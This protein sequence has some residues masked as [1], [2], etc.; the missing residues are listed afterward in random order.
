MGRPATIS[1][2]QILQ[3]ARAVFTQKGFSSAT[4]ADIARELRVT[5]AA[6]LRH[7]DSK[8]TLFDAAMRSNVELPSCIL[9]LDR[10]DA[11][12]DPRAVLRR[13]AEEWVPFANRTVVQNLVLSMHDRTNPTLLVPFDP[14]SENSPPRRG[15][16]IVTNYFRRASQAGVIAV[17]D[18]RAAA[19]LFMGSLFSYVFL[20]QVLNVAER[21]YPL[22][23]YVDSLLAL[24]TRGAIVPKKQGGSRGGS[25]KIPS[26]ANRADRDH[27]G[28]RG[29]PPSV[30][31]AEAAA[32]AAGSIRNARSADRQRG[33]ARRRPRHTRPR[34]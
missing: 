22:D 6:V 5:A 2:E 29:R 3:A 15:L 24:W 33:V 30:P 25:R 10:V 1:R 12:G 31:A 26:Q 11:S 9:D 17:E 34:R 20:H 8:Q 27:R 13:I 21:V 19:L 7:F 4:L 23:A 28:G 18:P 16:K 14:R 32:E